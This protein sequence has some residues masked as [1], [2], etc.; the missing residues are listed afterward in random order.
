VLS[1]VLACY[2]C[3]GLV[4]TQ[5]NVCGKRGDA[6]GK[7]AYQVATKLVREMMTKPQLDDFLTSV[8][9]PHIITVNAARL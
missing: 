9:Y 4:C 7:R 8:A 2:Y 1:A 5:Q 6:Q 3:Y